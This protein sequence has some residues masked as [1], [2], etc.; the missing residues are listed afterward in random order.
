[1][2]NNFNLV[3]R[4]ILSNELVNLLRKVFA[5]VIHFHSGDT[6]L[7]NSI[8]GDSIR[9]WIVSGGD[10]ICCD[11]GH[12]TRFLNVFFYLLVRTKGLID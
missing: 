3:E 8:K 2:L 5:F 10:T 12:N 1:M 11:T 6:I 9:K 7:G 4:F